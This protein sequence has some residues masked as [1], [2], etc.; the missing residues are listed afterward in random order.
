MRIRV[1][2]S[3]FGKNIT[4]PSYHDPLDD[5]HYPLTDAVTVELSDAT[6]WHLTG[7][8]ELML[9]SRLGVVFDARFMFTPGAIRFDVSGHDQV[10]LLIWS[11]KI[12]RPDGTVR[13]FS[14]D[15]VAP[16]PLCFD[17]MYYGL[18]CDH[19]T[20]QPGD[21]RVNPEA[22]NPLTGAPYFKCPTLGDF[23]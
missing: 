18:G 1:L 22:I 3:Q 20:M 12:Y 13:I 11:E 6:E 16:N 14:P 19:L 2:E 8:A 21:A 17:D 5:A 4:P 15:P 7:G 9:S 23:D 10:D